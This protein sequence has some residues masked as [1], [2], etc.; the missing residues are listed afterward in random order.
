MAHTLVAYPTLSSQG[1]ARTKWHTPDGLWTTGLLCTVEELEQSKMERPT[2]SLSQEGAT[3]VHG[4]CLLDGPEYWRS[5][6]LLRSVSLMRAPRLW[7]VT[8]QRFHVLIYFGECHIWVPCG[9]H[10]PLPFSNSSCAFPAPLKDHSFF[11]LNY[12]CY[13]HAL[14]HTHLLVCACV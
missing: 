1:A 5:K 9:H 7:P 6:G 2:D 11:S 12:Y 3:K 4:G 10:F 14:Q 13:T 8:S